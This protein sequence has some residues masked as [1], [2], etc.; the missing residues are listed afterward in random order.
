MAWA[1]MPGLMNLTRMSASGGMEIGYHQLT[2]NS[3]VR[4]PGIKKSGPCNA[5]ADFTDGPARDR[6]LTSTLHAFPQNKNA[7]RPFGARHRL[8]RPSPGPAGMPPGR[9]QGQARM[10]L[11]AATAP[12][13]EGRTPAREPS[14]RTSVQFRGLIDLDRGPQE[15][16]S[17][18]ARRASANAPQPKTALRGCL[19]SGKWP[20]CLI[21]AMP[22]PA[23]PPSGQ[24][25]AV[26]A[27]VARNPDPAVI[28]H[29]QLIRVPSRTPADTGNP[30]TR[31]TRRQCRN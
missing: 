26:P 6:S 1:M 30:R 23:R 11:P 10:T 21:V 16:K 13:V 29:R 22:W 3:R 5:T 25:E 9:S 17:T 19:S 24:V 28:P 15:V 2:A 14:C 8:H 18:P 12:D 4:C 27:P 31:R 20:S 7:G